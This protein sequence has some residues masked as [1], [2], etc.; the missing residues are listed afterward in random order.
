LTH[1][2]DEWKYGLER[3]AEEKQEELRDKAARGELL[4]VRDVMTIAG[5][6]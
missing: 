1:H 3:Q 2:G 4:T 6:K 5:G